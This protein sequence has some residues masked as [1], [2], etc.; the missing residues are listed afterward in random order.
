MT[1]AESLKMALRNEAAPALSQQLSAEE[2]S[3]GFDILMDSWNGKRMKTLLPLSCLE[4]SILF[5]IRD[6]H[7]PSSRLDRDR[8]TYL[9]TFPP[10]RDVLSGDVLHS[11]PTVYSPRDWKT[12]FTK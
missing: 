4:Y 10:T 2:C 8:K 5:S 3:V 11:N 1:D 6:L 12:A 7:S 9:S